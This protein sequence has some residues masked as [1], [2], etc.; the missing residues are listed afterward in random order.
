MLLCRG[1]LT[2]IKASY[3]EQEFHN[4]C[5]VYSIFLTF[6][7]ITKKIVLYEYC[8]AFFYPIYLISYFNANP[9]SSHHTVSINVS[10]LHFQM[11]T[12][13]VLGFRGFGF[14]GL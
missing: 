11:R 4:F 10:H 2:V 9:V 8:T 1:V 5:C 12:R 14:R 7:N 6:S 13:A 3:F